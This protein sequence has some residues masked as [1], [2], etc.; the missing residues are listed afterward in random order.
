MKGTLKDKD[1]K[2]YNF[3]ENALS[4]GQ[5]VIYITIGS[6]CCWADWSIEAVK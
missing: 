4:Q 6:E 1:L 3:L 5:K 2:I